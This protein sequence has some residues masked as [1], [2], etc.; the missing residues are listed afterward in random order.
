MPKASDSMKFRLDRLPDNLSSYLVDSLLLMLDELKRKREG[1]ATS[2]TLLNQHP[3]RY[4]VLDRDY[5]TTIIYPEDV[6]QA[7]QEARRLGFVDEIDDD[8]ADS[9]FSLTEAGQEYIGQ[10]KA[11]VGS[12]IQKYRQ[13]GDNWLSSAFNNAYL[14]CYG[15]PSDSGLEFETDL[16]SDDPSPEVDE[17]APLKLDRESTEYE[18]AVRQLEDVIEQL[19][20][21]NGYAATYPEE[22]GNVLWSLQ[23][24]LELLKEK[25]PTKSQVRAL[26]LAPLRL[27]GRRFAETSLGEIADLAWRAVKALFQ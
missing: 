8:F 16:D 22:R 4:L 15:M 19:R 14:R 5:I 18:V 24:G 1:P 10:Q 12:V 3:G 25:L 13:L 2:I 26:I 9:Y 6:E 7:L 17:W 11:D 21:D 27:L 23:S 20:R